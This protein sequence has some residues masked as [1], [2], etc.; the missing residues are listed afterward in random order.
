M[1]GPAATGG[2]A[3]TLKPAAGVLY[4]ARRRLYYAK[5]VL[6]GW[7]HAVWFATSL[8]AG[9]LLVACGHGALLVT[10]LAVYTLSVTGL[11]GISALYHRGTWGPAWLAVRLQRADDL[12]IFS[13]RGMATRH[14]PALPSRAFGLTCLT[15][16]WTLVLAAAAIHVCW[17][18]APEALVGGTFIG[19]GSLAR[20]AL[21]EVSIELASRPEC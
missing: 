11:F 21:P 15:V 3:I 5:P 6:R 10:A 9:P 14:L 12:M 17:P 7:L 8:A 20:L 4:D 19:L 1:A 16:M 2:G 13:H 18:G